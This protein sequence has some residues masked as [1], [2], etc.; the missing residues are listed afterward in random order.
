M[1]IQL[2]VNTL[3]L[4]FSI[5]CFFYVGAT[6]PQS[7]ASELGAEQWPQMLLVLLILALCFNIYKFF[8]ENSREA[9]GAAFKDF[10]PGIGRFVKSKLFIGMALLVIMALIYEELGF[11]VTSLF[12]LNAYGVLLGEKRPLRLIVCSIVITLIL[13]LGFAV[14]LGVL[15]PRGNVGFLRDLALGLEKLIAAVGL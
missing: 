12:F 9:I 14:F 15:L 7:A 13:Y 1:A 2:I 10:F 5:F 4:L 8:R 11:L 6:M 3:L